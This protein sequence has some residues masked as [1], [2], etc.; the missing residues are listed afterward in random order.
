M[1]KWEIPRKS[2]KKKNQSKPKDRFFIVFSMFFGV[3][4]VLIISHIILKYNNS[5]GRLI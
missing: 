3:G 4:H 1:I 5:L 2:D